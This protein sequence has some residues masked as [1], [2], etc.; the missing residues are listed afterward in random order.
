MRLSQELVKR[1]KRNISKFNLKHRVT[2]KQIYMNVWS[3][4]F[5]KDSGGGSR[6]DHNYSK[7]L[8]QM[9]KQMHVGQEGGREKGGRWRTSWHKGKACV[10]WK[11]RVGMAGGEDLLWDLG[12]T[13]AENEGLPSSLQVWEVFPDSTRWAELVSLVGESRRWLC[14]QWAEGSLVPRGLSLGLTPETFPEMGAF[15]ASLICEHALLAK[16]GLRFINSTLSFT[17]RL[18]FMKHIKTSYPWP[19]WQKDSLRQETQASFHLEISLEMKGM[20][21]KY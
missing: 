17:W 15:A 4:E 9:L 20:C 7:A 19:L 5:W 21:Q 1:L 16:Q 8:T 6:G 14:E 18:I 12:A 10:S 3:E 11:P 13:W 2:V